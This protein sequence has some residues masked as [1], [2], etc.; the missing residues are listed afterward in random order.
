VDFDSF[1]VTSR[2]IGCPAKLRLADPEAGGPS[3]DLLIHRWLRRPI[4][5]FSISVIQDQQHATPAYAGC[6]DIRRIVV[7][8][9][10]SP[11]RQ[12]SSSAPMIRSCSISPTYVYAVFISP[13]VAG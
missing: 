1:V 10:A 6:A 5:G 9:R 13:N 4:A 8:A 11:R 3:A 7:A 2:S 12:Q